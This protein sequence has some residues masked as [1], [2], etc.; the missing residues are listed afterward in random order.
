MKFHF[1]ALFVLGTLIAP[2]HSSATGSVHSKQEIKSNK[3]DEVYL[4]SVVRPDGVIYLYV[5]EG[6]NEITYAEFTSIGHTY[7]LSSISI[8]RTDFTIVHGEFKFIDENGNSKVVIL[9]NATLE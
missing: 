1:L 2:S 8:G 5:T 7:T 9:N 6:T 4:G 3:Y